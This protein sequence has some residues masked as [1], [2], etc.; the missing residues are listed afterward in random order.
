MLSYA[1]SS[2]TAIVPTHWS[3]T[4][5]GCWYQEEMEDVLRGMGIAAAGGTNRYDPTR[6]LGDAR[7]FPSMPHTALRGC[8][9]VSGTKIAYAATRLL[10]GRLAR[11]VSC[12][13]PEIKD[14]KPQ[15]QYILYQECVYAR[16]RRCPV[17]TAYAC[18]LGGVRYWHSVSFRG[19]LRDRYA[20]SGTDTANTATGLRG[21]SV[22]SGTLRSCRATG[23]RGCYAMSGTQ[24]PYGTTRPR[25]MD[26]RD[27]APVRACPYPR[28]MRCPVLSS[29]TSL[30]G[31]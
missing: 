5:I 16:A 29:R 17:L 8:Y 28:A 19:C 31:P 30:P 12:L 6:L 13:H 22:M 15:P 18:G 11:G 24:M 26:R 4:D 21:C 23:L 2:T 9:A 20:V 27:L 1:L 10:P 3:G 7:W 25:A 14:K